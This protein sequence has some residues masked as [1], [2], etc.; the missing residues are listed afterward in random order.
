MEKQYGKIMNYLK[1]GFLILTF[2]LLCFIV[3]CIYQQQAYGTL[4]TYFNSKKTDCNFGLP[5]N[6]RVVYNSENKKY[7]IEITNTWGKQFLWGRYRGWIDESFVV[8]T[9]FGDSCIAKSFAAQYLKEREDYNK[10]GTGY[11]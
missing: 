6:L 3:F 9:Y 4:G 5:K 1:N 7:A 11:K 8:N 10:K 2:L